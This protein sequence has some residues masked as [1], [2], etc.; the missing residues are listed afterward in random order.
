MKTW[1]SEKA[2]GYGNHPEFSKGD[3]EEVIRE[4]LKSE[5][6]NE[7]LFSRIELLELGEKIGLDPDTINRV[8]KNRSDRQASRKES[9]AKCEE[10]VRLA[11]PH[12]GRFLALSLFLFLLNVM[13]SSYMWCVFPILGL[14]LATAMKFVEE[15]EKFQFAEVRSSYNSRH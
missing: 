7:D 6:R 10:L 11:I 9:R 1:D 15:Y 14:G 3:V 12:G 2:A 4:C 8:L 5:N 13:V